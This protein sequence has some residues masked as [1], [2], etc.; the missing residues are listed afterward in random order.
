MVTVIEHPPSSNEQFEFLEA[1][2]PDERPGWTVHAIIEQ[3]RIEIVSVSKSIVVPGSTYATTVVEQEAH[4]VSSVVYLLRQRIE[5]TLE[6]MSLVIQ[7]ARARAAASAEAANKAEAAFKTERDELKKKAA[8]SA[9]TLAIV[10]ATNKRL[11]EK[12]II[13]DQMAADL[14]KL[15]D[16]LGKERY[17]QIIAISQ[18][19]KMAKSEGAKCQ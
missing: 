15:R 17:D 10:D 12:Q 19:E 8:D 14:A 13:M 1:D 3:Q 7:D 6:E 16:H 11:I 18:L 4:V 2:R 5:K 9:N